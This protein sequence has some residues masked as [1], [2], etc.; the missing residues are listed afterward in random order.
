M[1]R[2][3]TTTVAAAALLAGAA[4]AESRIDTTGATLNE[5]EVTF[6]NVTADADG[7]VVLHEV[8]DGQLVA[9][10]SI[11]HTSISAGENVNVTVASDVDLPEGTQFAAMLHVED[12]GNDTYDFADGSTDVDIPAMN[13][14]APVV[15]MLEATTEMMVEAE[16][17]QDTVTDMVDVS[18]VTVKG[19]VVTFPTVEA[20]QDGYLVIHS[21]K[22]GA[23]VVPASIGH[24]AVSAGTS[25]DVEV[26]LDA[27]VV[28]GD[29]YI[30]MLHTE[31]NGNTSY[32]FAD[33]MT[34]VDTPVM[35]NGEVVAVP[36]GG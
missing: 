17:M 10:A 14:D 6:T 3:F 21:I 23:P 9:P 32:D 16:M 7:Y 8:V 20:S 13:G 15:A 24:K 19:D 28:A 26:K 1:T 4:T 22:D 29:T 5:N 2:I 36:F 27:P 35:V 18:V 11:G 31:S 33:G 34:D 30:A 12:N 25:T